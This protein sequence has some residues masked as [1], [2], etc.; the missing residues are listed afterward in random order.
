LSPKEV[1]KLGAAMATLKSVGREQVE[2]AVTDFLTIADKS[3]DFGL[4]SDEYIRSVL[5]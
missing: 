3:S 4:D 5:T 1:Q 2:G